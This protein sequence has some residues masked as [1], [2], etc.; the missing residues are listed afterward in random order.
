MKAPPTT[1]RSLPSTKASPIIVG[2]YP[3]RRIGPPFF[4]PD[5]GADFNPPLSRRARRLTRLSSTAL[6][7]LLNDSPSNNHVHFFLHGME[8]GRYFCVIMTGVI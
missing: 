1:G 4:H 6:A 3:P 8:P 2:P 5:V 7:I